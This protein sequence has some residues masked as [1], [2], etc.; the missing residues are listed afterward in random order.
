MARPRELPAYSLRDDP[1]APDIPPGT[2]PLCGFIGQ[3]H[4]RGECIDELRST[5]AKLQFRLSAGRGKTRDS[6]I[7]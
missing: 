3:H 7:S 5:I 6:T 2:C 4:D 1:E